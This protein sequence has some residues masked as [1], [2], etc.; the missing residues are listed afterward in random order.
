MKLYGTIALHAQYTTFVERVRDAL[1]TAETTQN[2]RLAASR[3]AT[4]PVEEPSTRVSAPRRSIH[5]SIN[6]RWIR[7]SAGRISK[8]KCRRKFIP[9]K[10]SISLCASGKTVSA[11]SGVVTSSTVNSAT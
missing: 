11:K 1:A 5:G 6:S 10:P 8:L 3:H 2:D 9:T 4:L 7:R